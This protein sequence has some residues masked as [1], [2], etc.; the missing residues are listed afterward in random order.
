MIQPPSAVK[1]T[2]ATDIDQKA[3]NEW[4]KHEEAYVGVNKIAPLSINQNKR[5]NHKTNM[6]SN[7]SS[8][9]KDHTGS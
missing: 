1:Q 7:Y 8:T 3:D 2:E 9:N 6:N 5:K 4:K